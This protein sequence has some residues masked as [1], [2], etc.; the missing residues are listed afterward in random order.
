MDTLTSQHFRRLAEV[1]DA[2]CVSLLMPTHPSGHETIQDPIRFKN[3]LGK[4]KDVLIARGQRAADARRRLEPLGQLID[5]ASFWAYQREGLA[6]FCLPEETLVYGVPLPIP[7]R[8]VIGRHAY[9]VPLVP[10]FSEDV[11]FHVLALSP[12]QVR[13]L[14][15]TRHAAQE[16][17]LPGW[18]ENFE[19]LAAYIEEEPQLQF[20]TGAPPEVGDRGRAAMFHGHPGGDESSERKQRLLEYCRLV[21]ERVQKTVG[22]DATP[23]I[24]ACDQRLA[25]IYRS[26]SVHAR[27][28]GEPLA[29]NPDSRKPAELCSEAWTLLE[30]LVAEA[31][32]AAL[33]RYHQAMA[34]GR[35]AGRLEAVLPAA[36]EGR[37]D[38]LL[39]A[40]DG[41][42][43]GRYDPA[44][45]R[46]D[47]H[48]R[49]APDDEELVNLAVV[50]AFRQGA[51]VHT[52]PEGQ[53]PD[54]QP[55]VAVLRY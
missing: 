1:A 46:L 4:A 22:G 21:D 6:A 28:V 27:I 43:W 19:Q 18:P 5:D 32:N 3:L 48:D 39:V 50:V 9:L 23:L 33:Q 8:I 2:S 7:E 10:V 31:R 29:G 35:G 47:V 11:R 49:P 17:D 13:L 30:P 55:A 42:R 52:L 44:Q 34:N 14:E 38:T 41:Q 37:V 36:H 16:L 24:L 20:H 15:C 26:A 54:K 51:A 25:A 45:R 40:A 12:R 53:M